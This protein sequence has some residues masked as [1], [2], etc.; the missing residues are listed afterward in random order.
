[1]KDKLLNFLIIFL[2]VYLT[3]SLFQVKDKENKLSGNIV[4]KTSETYTI[5][6]RVKIEIKNETSNRFT[7]NTC[8][9]FSI[10]KDSNI[11]KQT[12]CKNVSIPS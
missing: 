11:I 4:L 1:M 12:D 10:K 5:P 3:L 8:S 6:V 7:F 9:D 2:L